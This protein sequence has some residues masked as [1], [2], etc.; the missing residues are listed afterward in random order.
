MAVAAAAVSV[1]RTGTA[2]GS[3][4]QKRAGTSTLGDDSAVEMLSDWNLTRLGRIVSC[5]IR[6]TLKKMLLTNAV[7]VA[8]L[9]AIL[10]S[11]LGRPSVFESFLTNFSRVLGQSALTEFLL[12]RLTEVDKG[13]LDLIKGFVTK[14]FPKLHPAQGDAAIQ[15]IAMATVIC[16][17]VIGASWIPPFIANTAAT[18]LTETNAI[19]LMEIVSRGVEKAFDTVLLVTHIPDYEFGMLLDGFDRHFGARNLVWPRFVDLLVWRTE[20]A[21]KEF[22]VAVW[23]KFQND[24]TL[25]TKREMLARYTPDA[26]AEKEGYIRL[27]TFL[28]ALLIGATWK[29]A[30]PEVALPPRAAAAAAAAPAA[31]PG[32]VRPRNGS[33]SGRFTAVDADLLTMRNESKIGEVFKSGADAA[34]RYMREVNAIPDEE[35]KLILRHL[36]HNPK[37]HVHWQDYFALLP[38]VSVQSDI[39]KKRRGEVGAWKEQ[40][41]HDYI[42][43]AFPDTRGESQPEQIKRAKTLILT[44]VLLGVTQRAPWF[45]HPGV[46]MDGQPAAPR[47]PAALPPALG[48]KWP[49]N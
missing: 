19:V 4:V 45:G 1:Q 7:P 30:P 13:K 36:Q 37:L 43:R 44:A 41:I 12:S 18:M 21:K 42:H 16:V 48:T 22:F 46:Q 40:L 47:P 10:A 23:I 29:S 49:L 17:F 38:E 32:A 39:L 5:G 35:L 25:T 31:A 33:A 11:W 20:G 28:T 26:F 8:S 24:A 6:P 3:A 14:A 27:S 9:R 2:A 15:Q 34:I